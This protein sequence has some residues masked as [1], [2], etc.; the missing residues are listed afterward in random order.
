MDNN[1]TQ[2]NDDRLWD[3]LARW[4]ESFQHGRDLPAE[5]LCRDCPEIL[6]QLKARIWALKRTAW[7][8]KKI[9][10]DADSEPQDASDQTPKQLG[11]Y[12]I[13][14]RIGAGGGGAVF[15]AVHRRMERTVVLKLLPRSTPESVARF[16]TEV[17]AAAKLVQ[18]NI[19]TAYDAGEQDGVSFLVMEFTEG[20]DLHRHVQE[21]GPLPVD[22]AVNYV[23]QAAKGLDFAHGQGIVHRDVKPANLLL[24]CDGTVKI[25]DMGLAQ[26]RAS[27]QPQAVGTP[28][29]MAPELAL[30]PS[31]ADARSDIYALG[32]TLWYLLTAKPLF[33]AST[34]IQKILAHR[35]QPV[36]SLRKARPEV[37][38]AL[39]AFFRRMVAKRPEHRFGSME[40]LITALRAVQQPKSRRPAW[41][42][43]LV[44]LVAVVPTTAWITVQGHRNDTSTEAATSKPATVTDSTEDRS[45]A[46]WALSVGG[47]VTVQ[48]Q[49]GRQVVVTDPTVLPTTA[50]RVKAIDLH[51]KSQ[52]TDDALSVLKELD[53]ITD[54]NLYQTRITDAGTE[55]LR[56]LT[57]LE[58]LRL[59]ETAI[60][61]EGLRNLDGLTKLKMLEIWGTQISN[62][63]LKHLSKMEDLTW[64]ILADTK[65]TDDGLRHLQGLLNLRDLRL[66]RTK[67]TDDGMKYITSLKELRTLEVYDTPITDAAL[68]PLTVLKNLSSLNLARTKITDA[69]VDDLAKMRNLRQLN[70]D[71]TQ[72]TQVGI[73]RLQAALPVC[74]ISAGR[75]GERPLQN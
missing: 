19:V 75:I 22:K 59:S 10:D 33:E 5:E 15:K 1:K 71:G 60:T 45:A 46:K 51:G 26:V 4:E 24:T 41:I 49:D 28:D 37:T 29:F 42:W 38:D 40:E 30:D 2:T 63:G 36:P 65:I 73:K 35:E 44:V 72:V 55:H 32:C 3:A 66:A 74:T 50:F 9:A 12:T 67:I 43:G 58:T 25:L 7:M 16:Q 56:D 54:L 48:L 64:L 57:S 14:E 27:Q 62:D 31:K 13:L 21:H 17:K 20:T 53:Q 6:D 8:T 68:K 18:P 69:G 52:A 47:K 23:L 34:V 39:D 70:L 61:D 11:E